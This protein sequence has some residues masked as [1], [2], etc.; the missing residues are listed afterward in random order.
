MEGIVKIKV[1]VSIFLIVF[2]SSAGAKSCDE[3][4][5]LGLVEQYFAA[6]DKVSKRGSSLKDIDD[7]LALTHAEVRYVHVEYQA[8]FSRDEWREAFK[9]NLDSGRYTKTATNQIRVLNSISGKNHLAVEYS[10][11]IINRHGAWQPTDKYLALFGFKDGKLSL[12]KEL[13]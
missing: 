2:C 13:W 6:L 3:N 10:H 5:K 12:I 9:R 4:C 7:L 11:G 1:V 8:D